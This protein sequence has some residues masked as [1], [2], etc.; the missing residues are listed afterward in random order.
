M[1]RNQHDEVLILWDVDKTLVNLGGFSRSLYQS[2]FLSVTGKPLEHLA[3]MAGQT[4]RA[5]A[6]ETFELHGIRASDELFHRFC[7]AL[8]KAAQDMKNRIHE[9]GKALPGAHEA[10]ASFEKKRAVQSLV[11][12]NIQ[13]VARN[14]LE[15]FGLADRL[16]FE[17]GGYGD[18]S[19][20]R[21]DLVRFACERA[22][23]K[24]GVEFSGK[25][26]FVI[27]DTPHDIKSAHDAGAHAI[28]V[29]TGN[30][31]TQDLENAGA[32]LVLTSLTGIDALH[33]MIQEQ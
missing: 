15:A 18:Y 5:I 12:G 7:T 6:T 3:P 24:H 13:P 27:G 14:K 8:A 9:I 4:E 32:D 2:A 1:S 16:D 19:K 25:R 10:I 31:S 22:S 20:D 30:S 28:G 21:P 11:T 23:T 33:N 17:I 26:T 29:A